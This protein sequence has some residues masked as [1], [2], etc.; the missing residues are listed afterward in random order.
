MH[1]NTVLKHI[2]VKIRVYV[3]GVLTCQDI[4]GTESHHGQETV[5]V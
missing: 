4:I 3:K 1:N 5:F 2:I